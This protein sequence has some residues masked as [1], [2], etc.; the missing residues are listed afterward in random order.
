[1]PS[2]ETQ[3]VFSLRPARAED[4][5]FL[6][7]LFS[8]TQDQ[9]A[10][11]RANEQ[12]WRMLVDVQYRGRKMTYEANFPAAEDS[13]L[14]HGEQPVGRLLVS[15]QADHWRVLDIAVSSAARG[16]GCASW[17]L[18]QLQQQAAE[19]GVPLELT[20]R[21]FNPARRLYERLGFRTTAEE[22]MHVAMAW[23]GAVPS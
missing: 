5:D 8:E 15:R 13:I 6:F 19:A 7:L 10:M 3:T 20:V 9:L 11:L 14:C 1:M 16:Q 18:R 4:E 17:A 22:E 21:P 12:M 23:T 2:T